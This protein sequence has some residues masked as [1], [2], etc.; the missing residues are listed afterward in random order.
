MLDTICDSF[1]NLTQ[2]HFIAKSQSEA[3]KLFKEVIDC[4]TAIILLDFA[5]NYGFIV[6]DAVQGHHW[7]NSQATVHPFVIYLKDSPSSDLKCIN[8]CIISDNLKHDTVAVHAF[9]TEILTAIKTNYPHLTNMIYFSDGASSQYKKFKNL[10]NLCNHYDD[11]NLSAEW[12]FFATSHGKSPCDG[13]GGTVKRLVARASLQAPI[14][15]QILTPHDMY[16][17]L[18]NNVDGIDFFFISQD[19]VKLNSIKYKLPERFE[20]CK[21]IAGVR[22]HHSFIPCVGNK[23]EMRRVSLDSIYTIVTLGSGNEEQIIVRWEDCKPGKYIACLYDAN[24]YVGNI[25]D[26]S[27]EHSDVRVSFMTKSEK[28]LLS[29]PIGSRKDEC[30]VPVQHIICIIHAPIAQGHRARSFIIRH[31]DLIKIQTLFPK[32]LQHY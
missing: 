7:D 8:M 15:N 13:I 31:D 9:I 32:M 17:W 2:H 18:K 19:Q 4:T 1:N 5:E 24:W 22:S 25:K 20:A 26:Y 10:A 29:W 3:L 11:H 27:D 14:N 16:N 6:Q 28:N 12:H 30:W 21:T 23:L